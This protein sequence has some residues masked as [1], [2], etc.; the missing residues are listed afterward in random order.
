MSVEPG[1]SAPDYGLMPRRFHQLLSLLPPGVPSFLLPQLPLLAN[2]HNTDLS[3]R[4]NTYAQAS[5]ISQNL[6]LSFSF[7]TASTSSCSSLTPCPRLIALRTQK[8]LDLS[9]C[10]SKPPS[11]PLTCPDTPLILASLTC[12]P[13]LPP[14]GSP[15]KQVWFPSFQNKQKTNIPLI[16]HPL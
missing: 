10:A 4:L 1:L 2:L 15:G 3:P 12:Q 14:D 5:S 6:L 16:P 9:F 13:F 7:Q 8:Q 11:P